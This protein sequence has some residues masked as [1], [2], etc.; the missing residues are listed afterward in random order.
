MEIKATYSENLPSA[1]YKTHR[2]GIELTRQVP[3]NVDAGTI[4]QNLFLIAKA[5]VRAEV[6]R[7]KGDSALNEMPVGS[8]IQQQQPVN[9]TA[10]NQ[11]VPFQRNNPSTNNN[12]VSGNDSRPATQKQIKYL[13]NL[14]QKSN[15]S[16]EQVRNLAQQYYGKSSLDDLTAKEASTLIDSLSASKNKA[17]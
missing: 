11:Q 14:G 12:S 2:W 4:T 6:E 5:S 16:I 7:A 1:D 13:F 8:P 10:T 15:M 3:D 17:A 9:C